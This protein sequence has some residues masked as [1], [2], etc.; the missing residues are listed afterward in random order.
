MKFLKAVL[1]FNLALMAN[2][3]YALEMPVSGSSLVIDH[4]QTWYV[5][6]G[7]IFDFS[8]FNLKLGGTLDI[9]SHAQDASFSITAT[10]DIVLEGLLNVYLANLTFVSDSLYL[11]GAIVARGTNSLSIYAK[12]I[13]LAD[14]SLVDI[15][16][17]GQ[18]GNTN[19]SPNSGG[20]I[21]IAVGAY[22]PPGLP[23]EVIIG[24]AGMPVTNPWIIASN[25]PEPESLAFLL[26]GLS[27]IWVAIRRR[28]V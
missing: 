7:D 6:D 12:Y 28:V 9:Y 10:N 26:A 27:L 13:T 16:A 22:D 2:V 24:N 19:G 18:S 25:V 20:A 14:G 3:V 21:G 4:S 17:N 8:S 11:S 15:R 5:N 1:I 23:V